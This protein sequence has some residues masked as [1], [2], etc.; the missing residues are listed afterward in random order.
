M[1]GEKGWAVVL[2][3]RRKEEEVEEKGILSLPCHDKREWKNRQTTVKTTQSP[4]SLISSD[5]SSSPTPSPLLPH[6]SDSDG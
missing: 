2:C 1:G 5:R 3:P 6:Y 4:Y